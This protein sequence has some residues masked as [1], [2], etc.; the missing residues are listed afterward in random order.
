[1]YPLTIPE[2]ELKNKVA[3]D[4]FSDFDSTEIIENIDFCVIQNENLF[5]N[6]ALLW[7]EAKRATKRTFTSP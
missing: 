2:E 7:A 3:R 1:M 6:N 4:F 5:N